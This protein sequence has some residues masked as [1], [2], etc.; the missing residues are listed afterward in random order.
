MAMALAPIDQLGLWVQGLQLVDP[1]RLR[2]AERDMRI[3]ELERVRQQ[4][5]IVGQQSL[6]MQN[7]DLFGKCQQLMG[8]HATA[9]WFRCLSLPT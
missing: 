4:V 9:R 6:E 1:R 7:V 5:S 2:T 8:M 3:K